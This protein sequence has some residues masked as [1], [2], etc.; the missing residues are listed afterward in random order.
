MRQAWKQVGDKC[1]IM[2][3]RPPR[4]GD[5]SEHSEWQPSVGD[6]WETHVK[7]RGPEHRE[8]ETS[9]RQVGDKC[10]ILRPRAPRMEDKWETSLKSR[11]PGRPERKTS[12]RQVGD[13]CKIMRPRPPRLGNK[14][15]ASVKSCGPEHPEWETSV[16]D[17]CKIMRP[18]PPRVGDK[19]GRQVADKCKSMRPRAPRAGPR[20]VD[21]WETNATA[22]GPE[23]PEWETSG[24]QVGAKC[25]SMRPE[26]P[27]WN[28]SPETKAKSCGPGMQH[29]ERSKNP[30]QVNLFG[31]EPHAG[32]PVWGTIKNTHV[33]FLLRGTMHYGKPWCSD[34]KSERPII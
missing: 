1:K 21:K 33:F 28:A 20:V 8:R 15:E 9:G 34:L 22:C 24:R 30:I 6:K 27:E 11:G 32:K 12:G 17:K 19:C 13:K 7:S 26:H 29:F 3:P 18:R 16:G 25:K 2:R 5:K 14:W 10:K 31:E 23:H 4:V